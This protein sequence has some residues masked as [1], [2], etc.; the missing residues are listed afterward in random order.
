MKAKFNRVALVN[1]ILIATP[2]TSKSGFDTTG[3]LLFAF[4]DDANLTI[5]ASSGLAGL[6]ISNLKGSEVYG[7]AIRFLI[8]PNILRPTLAALLDEVIT[9]EINTAQQ[10]SKTPTSM[11]I[12]AEHGEYKIGLEKDPGREFPEFP[13][14]INPIDIKEFFD[15]GNKVAFATAISDDIR[16]CMAAVHFHVTAEGLNFVANDGHMLSRYRTKS[17][18]AIKKSFTLSKQAFLLLAKAAEFPEEFQV[19]FTDKI[20][21]FKSASCI[22]FATLVADIYPNYEAV[23]PN[24]DNPTTFVIERDSLIGCLKRFKSYSDDNRMTLVLTDKNEIELSVANDNSGSAGSEKL[25]VYDRKGVIT[26]GLGVTKLLTV[27]SALSFDSVKMTFNRPNQAVYISDAAD[28]KGK[29][30]FMSLVMP[31]VDHN[32]RV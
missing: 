4:D 14:E 20:I 16:P 31:M 6:R 12:L 21:V 18:D 30:V 23:L 5:S 11:V 24:Y 9:I 27:F 26:V 25:G 19:G 2:F 29:N 1:A 13:D 8:D 3:H 15:G 7:D 28:E 10:D 22:F 17:I 32:V